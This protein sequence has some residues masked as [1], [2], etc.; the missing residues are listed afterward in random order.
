M[1]KN[2]GLGSSWGWW[3]ITCVG[4]NLSSILFSAGWAWTDLQLTPLE[5]THT[6]FGLYHLNLSMNVKGV[7]Y[8]HGKKRQRTLMDTLSCRSSMNINEC[9]PLVSALLVQTFCAN[10]LLLSSRGIVCRYRA[11]IQSFTLPW[12]EKLASK[13]AGYTDGSLA[14]VMGPQ[15]IMDPMDMFFR[16]WRYSYRWNCFC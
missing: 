4:P 14:A 10:L 16:R 5:L 6:S 15:T 3:V 9:A 12:R 13:H 7:S 1:L 8:S 2:R 11:S